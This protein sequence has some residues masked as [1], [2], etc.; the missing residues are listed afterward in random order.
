VTDTH[1]LAIFFFADG[2]G[3]LKPR[4]GEAEHGLGS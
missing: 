3:E 2:R 1:C 4:S